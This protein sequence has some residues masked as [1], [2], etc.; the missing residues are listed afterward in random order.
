MDDYKFNLGVHHQLIMDILQDKKGNIWFSSWNGG[1]VWRYDGRTF[2][3]YLPA[4]DYY[5]EKEDE[6]TI[7][8]Y[9]QDCAF[10]VSKKKRYVKTS[11]SITDDMIFSMTEDKA[12]NIWL[13]TRRHGACKFDG[14]PFTSFRE[15]EGF[16]SYGITSVSEDKKGIIWLGTDKNGFYSFDG[17]TLKN[18]QKKMDLPMFQ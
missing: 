14:K 1:G 10:N 12:G 9:K 15:K 17:Q 3:N 4:A 11:E 8:S 5:S 16:V 2:K 18:L 6:R 13:A 7:G